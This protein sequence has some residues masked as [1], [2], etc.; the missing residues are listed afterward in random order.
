LVKK[1]DEMSGIQ[2]EK[3]KKI[4]KDVLYVCA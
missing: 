2:K 3:L 4:L 1:Y